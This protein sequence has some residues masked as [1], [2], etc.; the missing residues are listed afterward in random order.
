M[1]AAASLLLL[2]PAALRG[3]ETPVFSAHSELVVLHVTVRDRKGTYVDDL[4]QDAFAVVEDGQAQSVKLFSDTDTPVTVGLLVDG[5]ASMFGN[6]TLAVAG[7]A[8]FVNASGKDDELF[9]LAFNEIV[10]PALPP[11]TLFTRDSGILREGLERTII[12]RGRT[13]LYDA[14][15]AGVD[16][17][18]RGTRERKALVVLSDGGDNA[19]RTSR[20]R[21]VRKALESNAVVYTIALIEPG[22]RGTNPELLE[23]LSESTGGRSF[24]PSRPKDLPEILRDIALEIR[25]TYTIGYTSTNDR[26]RRQLQAGPRGGDR[27]ARAAVGRPESHRLRRRTRGAD[28][29]TAGP[30]VW[31]AR[32][33]ILVGAVALAW[34]GYAVLSTRSAQ[35]EYRDALE[36]KRSAPP[37]EPSKPALPITDAARRAHRDAAGS[38]PRPVG[39]RRRG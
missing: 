12:A 32:L 36:V 26:A 2:R 35:R 16:Y 7:A 5:S 13:A 8:E 28:P 17:L 20:E 15:S 11:G 34:A 19:S 30:R 24:R 6:R 10:T 22:M 25:H 3:Q 27:S 4:S 14:I 1:L 33:L 21:A 31:L 23:E 29:M 38:T 9:A 37:P 39:C 18:A